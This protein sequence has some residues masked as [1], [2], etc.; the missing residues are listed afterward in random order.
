MKKILIIVLLS[1][2]Y[3]FGDTVKYQEKN[4]FYNSVETLTNVELIEIDRGSKKTYFNFRSLQTEKVYSIN[5]NHITV[6]QDNDGNLKDFECRN[7][8]RIN[9]KKLNINSTARLIGGVSYA[10]VDVNDDLEIF[11][12]SKTERLLGFKFGIEKEGPKGAIIGITY[13]NRGFSLDRKQEI[14]SIEYNYKVNYFTGYIIKSIPIQS[15]NALI[16]VEAGYFLSADLEVKQCALG[17]GCMSE[18][19]EYDTEDWEEEDG[20]IIDV[21]PIFGFRVPISESTFLNGTY[22]WGLVNWHKKDDGIDFV[23]RGFQFYL[24]FVL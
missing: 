7:L 18:K 24:S 10:N 14:E 20:N 9:R 16:G 15:I 13:T 1:F 17:Y 3:I 2:G 4:L 6:W 8:E 5:C 11:L 23:N 21:G 12:G 19:E 22:Y